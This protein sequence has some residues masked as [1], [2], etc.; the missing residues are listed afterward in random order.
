M[1]L[2]GSS[3]HHTS[4][5]GIQTGGVIGTT[6]QPV[7][8]PAKLT[9]FAYG[10]TGAVTG[11]QPCYV[12]TR[13]IREFSAMGLIIDSA[14]EFVERGD[15]VAL[16]ALLD[17]QF[18]LVGMRVQDEKG[19]KLG[20]VSDF[21]LDV[22]SYYVQQLV[23]KRP[24]LSSLNDTELIVHRTQII[25]INNDAIVVHSEAKAPEPERAEVP[26]SYINPFRKP[27]EVA[28]ESTRSNT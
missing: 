6:G 25:E 23:V 17:L 16:D 12:L 19:K 18:L 4:V 11:Q 27:G 8:D 28:A 5:V 2:L 22:A 1:I 10:I 7:I 9:I 20:K 3:L 26:G 13:D 21:T 15:V 14:D 24:L